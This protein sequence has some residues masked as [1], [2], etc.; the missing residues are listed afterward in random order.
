MGITGREIYA[1]AGLITSLLAIGVYCC[2]GL[3]IFPGLLGICFGI[4]ALRSC[5]RPMAMASI[6]MGAID[7]ALG[8]Y[9]A[10]LLFAS[11]R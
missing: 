6:T 10:P 8:L 7:F 2:P 3:P 5:S 11:G 4:Y 1:V 9:T